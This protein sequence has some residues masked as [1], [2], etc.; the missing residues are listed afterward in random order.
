MSLELIAGTQTTFD[1]CPLPRSGTVSEA[2]IRIEIANRRRR[3]ERDCSVLLTRADP[4]INRRDLSSESSAN[5]G[6]R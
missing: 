4:Q 3:D 5:T 2:R 6:D 1:D